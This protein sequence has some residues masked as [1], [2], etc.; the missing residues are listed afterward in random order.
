[1]PRQPLIPKRKRFFIGAEGKSERSFAR[2][3]E[4]LRNNPNPDVHLDIIVC[5]GGDGLAAAEYAVKRYRERAREH[6]KF[7]AGLILIDSDRIEEDRSHGRNPETVLKDESLCLA[8]MRPNLEGVLLRLH[9]DHEQEFVA[10]DKTLWALR[11][12]WPEYRKPASADAL[13]AR[14]DLNDLQRAARHD[15]ELRKI[16]VTLELPLR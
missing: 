6:G 2:W 5:D 9:R 13:D 14:F 10:A 3:L 12:Q 15:D 16:L 8:Y 4:R 7:D 1:M 11:K